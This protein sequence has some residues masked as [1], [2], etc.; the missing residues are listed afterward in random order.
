MIDFE[1]R[2]PS[3]PMSIG[4]KLFMASLIVLQVAPWII[5]VV[6]WFR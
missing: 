6:G 1:D 4:E 2:M 5:T 3:P